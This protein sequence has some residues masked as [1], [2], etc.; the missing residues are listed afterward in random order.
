MSNYGKNGYIDFSKL[1]FLLEEKQKNKQWLRDNGLH[2]ATVAKLT[3]NAN[4]T[5]EVICH[6]CRLLD[7][8]PGD[9]MEYKEVADDN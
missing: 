5:C 9:I 3:K 2:A 8:Q 1:F 4:V 6:I 7:C